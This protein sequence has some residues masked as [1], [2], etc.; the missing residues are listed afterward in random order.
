MHP[1]APQ[2]RPFR[3]HFMHLFR[4]VLTRSRAAECRKANQFSAHLA[5][6]V[7]PEA[8]SHPA[9]AQ[10]SLGRGGRTPPC[11]P[12]RRRCAAPGLGYAQPKAPE[13]GFS[14]IPS[15]ERGP[16]ATAADSC[17]TSLFPFYVRLGSPVLQV[18]ALSGR[19]DEISLPSAAQ[20]EPFLGLVGPPDRPR[21]PLPPSNCAKIAWAG[22]FPP[23][24]PPPAPLRGA[25][26]GLCP[27]RSPPKKLRLRRKIE[28]SCS[29][30]RTALKIPQKM[31]MS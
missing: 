15:D 14:R 23:L 19:L 31:A 27:A 13:R 1:I 9:T 25:R 8:L 10:K 21:G 26:A 2:R 16:M 20:S 18:V 22:S 30:R 7:G 5:L 12:P 6:L 11:A 17:F 29:Q 3:P 24:R 4:R 28:G